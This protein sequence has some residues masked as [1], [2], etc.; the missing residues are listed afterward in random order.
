MFHPLYNHNHTISLTRVICLCILAVCMFSY[1]VMLLINGD[2]PENNKQETPTTAA[3]AIESTPEQIEEIEDDGVEAIRTQ[4]LKEL[5]ACEDY[6]KRCGTLSQGFVGCT[7]EFSPL[8]T[9][10]YDAVVDA[11]DDGFAVTLKAKNEQAKDVCAFISVNSNGER[12]ATDSQGV[13][14]NE[15]LKSDVFK[16][17]NF[18]I[19]R[20]TDSVS[21]NPAPSGAQPIISETAKAVSTETSQQM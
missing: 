13:A 8:V 11:A 6:M 17:Q 21:V 16:T 10:W 15:C 4:T 14:H 3:Q 18:E 7:W 20:D 1:G 19:Q 12:V 5:A 9:K 2:A